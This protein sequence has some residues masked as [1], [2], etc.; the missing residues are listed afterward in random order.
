MVGKLPVNR[1]PGRFYPLGEIHSRDY[2]DWAREM[3]LRFV[4]QLSEVRQGGGRGTFFIR[5]HEDCQNLRQSLGQGTWRETTIQ[6]LFIRPFIEGTPASLALCITQQ[7]ILMSGLQ[8]QLI[9]LPY[10]KGLE[11]NGVFC[12]HSWGGRE[13]SESARQEAMQQGQVIGEYLA[14]LG[15]RG[16]LGIDFVIGE[17]DHRV[18]PLEINP[19]LTGAFPVLSQIHL[20]NGLI[21]LE[22]FHILE[23]L[24]IPYDIDVEELNAQYGHTMP[25]SHLL[26]FHPEKKGAA[27]SGDLDAGIYEHDPQSGGMTLVERACGFEKIKNER[28]FMVVDGPPG[29]DPGATGPLFRWCRMLFSHPIADADGT[30]SRE[31]MLCIKRV[32]D[33]IFQ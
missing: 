1:V 5:S 25:G 23:F 33:G 7:G 2:R 17:D 3:G 19:R 32:L 24:D 6:T 14:D 20:K 29:A 22:A 13:W 9:D 12:G 28:Q 27:I 8:R 18:Y 16:I 4:V 26:L 31:T 10:C 21:P 15:Y 30:L 11:E